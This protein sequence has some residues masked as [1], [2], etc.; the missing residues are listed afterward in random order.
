MIVAKYNLHYSGTKYKVRHPWVCKYQQPISNLLMKQDNLYQNLIVNIHTTNY[1]MGKRYK[2]TFH[3]W[4]HT[5]NKDIC[6]KM[7]NIISNK[8]NET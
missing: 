8:E 3:Q 2:K 1:K 5:D 4:R 7:L 6:D